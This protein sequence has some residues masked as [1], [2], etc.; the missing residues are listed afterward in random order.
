MPN[1][2]EIVEV[3]IGIVDGI[4]MLFH[5]SRAYFPNSV[6]VYVNGQLRVAT[7]PDGWVEIDPL[8]GL[9]Q[10]KITP[11]PT[12]SVQIAYKIGRASCRE[13]V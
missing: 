1:P 11:I 5:T 9:V 12:D 3:A 10:L 7:A 6:S 2:N 13:R 8:T 4:N